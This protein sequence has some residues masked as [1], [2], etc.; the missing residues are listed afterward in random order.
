MAP[1]CAF[2]SVEEL[3]AS[4]CRRLCLDLGRAGEVIEAARDLG[5]W[6]VPPRRLVTMWWDTSPQGG[7]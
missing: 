2:E 6:P 3:A 4:A 7:K 5:V 1:D